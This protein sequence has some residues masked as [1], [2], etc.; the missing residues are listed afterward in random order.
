VRK[1]D[2]PTTPP[3]GN[4]TKYFSYRE[5]W[6][7]IKLARE[8]GFFLE[9]IAIQ[10]SIIADRLTGYLIVVGEIPLETRHRSL[11]EVIKLW[12]KRH[13]TNIEVKGCSNLQGAVDAWRR[14]RNEAVHRIVQSLP[15]SPTVPIDDFLTLAEKAASEG[16]L[17]AKAVSAWCTK[18]RKQMG[19]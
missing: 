17:L 14:S 7:R 15:G 12:K 4:A 6:T 9:A 18:A 8:A 1:S 5:A 11:G 3:K 16:D 13:P 19:K 2:L 10:E